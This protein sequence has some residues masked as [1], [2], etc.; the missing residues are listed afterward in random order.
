MFVVMLEIHGYHLVSP[1][2]L[3]LRYPELEGALHL[4]HTRLH[5]LC[6]TAVLSTTITDQIC[7]FV[8]AAFI[9]PD[10]AQL[11]QRIPILFYLLLVNFNRK[12]KAFIGFCGRW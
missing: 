9:F 10:C 12:F 8:W 3:Y 11:A 1:S 2:P 4:L 7:L 6:S 5:N